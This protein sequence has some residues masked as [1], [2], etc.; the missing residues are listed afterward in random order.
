MRF[1][2]FTAMAFLA[3]KIDS[4]ILL[5]QKLFVFWMQ[6]QPKA[7]QVFANGINAFLL[8]YLFLLPLFQIPEAQTS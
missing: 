5:N 3:I 7:T 4:L 6:C 8:L 1:N 2:N